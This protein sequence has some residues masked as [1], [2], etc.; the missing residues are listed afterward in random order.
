MEKYKSPTSFLDSDSPEVCRFA[1]EKAGRAAEPAEQAKN[2]FYEVRDCIRYNP[3][4]IS[5]TPRGLKASTTLKTGCGWC[6][7]KAVLLAACCRSLGIPAGLGFADIRNPLANKN[8][9]EQMKTHVFYWHGYTSICLGGR[10]VKATPAFNIELCR[11][12][13]LKPVEFDGKSDALFHSRDLKGNR[14]IDYLNYR[15]EFSDVP[16]D[17]IIKSFRKHYSFAAG[18]SGTEFF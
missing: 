6:V 2:L 8:L 5:L 10:W 12:F 14:H 17:E 16:L 18:A 1:D 15:G 4:N 7:A 3:Y 13:S 11:K 9:L